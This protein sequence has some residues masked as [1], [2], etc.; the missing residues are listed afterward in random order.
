MKALIVASIATV[1]LLTHFSAQAGCYS[2]GR[3]VPC[4]DSSPYVS[5]CDCTDPNVIRNNPCM[6]T[7]KY[8]EAFG[9]VGAR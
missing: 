5:E 3:F 2:C 6:S 1:I 4:E 9:N 8:C 7:S